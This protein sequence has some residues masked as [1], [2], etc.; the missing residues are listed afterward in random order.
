M[1]ISGYKSSMSF[2]LRRL[3][4]SIPV[5][6]GI[7]IIAFLLIHLVPGDPID[8]MLGSADAGMSA[9]RTEM[10]QQAKTGGDHTRLKS[11]NGMVRP[12][13]CPASVLSWQGS[14]TQT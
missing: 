14:S 8:A 10:A 12:C 2:V 3:L 9:A 1:T 4:A 11:A 6:I 7:T 5:V 13:S